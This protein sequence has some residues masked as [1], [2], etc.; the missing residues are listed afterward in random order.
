MVPFGRHITTFTQ[1]WWWCLN[2][3]HTSCKHFTSSWHW[4]P[5]ASPTAPP[6]RFCSADAAT[7]EMESFYLLKRHICQVQCYGKNLQGRNVWEGEALPPLVSRPQQV[8]SPGGKPPW[9]RLQ[10]WQWR[11]NG[12]GNYDCIF[13]DFSVNVS[14]WNVKNYPCCR[15]SL[16]ACF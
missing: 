16:G 9:G 3:K 7:V 12:N 8:G 10:W 1:K 6:I 14:K 13:L 15:L 4:P 2:S 11:L 5:P